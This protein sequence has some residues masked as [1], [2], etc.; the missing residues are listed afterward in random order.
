MDTDFSFYDLKTPTPGAAG[1]NPV[2]RASKRGD[3]QRVSPLLLPGRIRKPVK[4]M[5]RWGIFRAWIYSGPAITTS[6]QSAPLSYR[7][8]KPSRARQLQ[9]PLKS[10][11]SRVGQ[12][13]CFSCLSGFMQVS[14]LYLSPANWTAKS[15]KAKN[16]TKKVKIGKSEPLCLSRLCAG[17]PLRPVSWHSAPQ[18]VQET[19]MIMGGSADG[20]CGQQIE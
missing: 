9:T 14:K 4:K 12:Q 10:E 15:K 3:T 6:L 11:P 20:L 5:P 8:H 18:A 13:W 7:K 17:N 2:G 16:G 1:S 19:A